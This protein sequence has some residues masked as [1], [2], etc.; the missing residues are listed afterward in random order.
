MNRLRWHQNFIF[1]ARDHHVTAS[2]MSAVSGLSKCVQAPELKNSLR[3]CDFSSSVCS[4]CPIDSLNTL[5][6]VRRL[7]PSCGRGHAILSLHLLS[8]TKMGDGGDSSGRINSK[9]SDPYLSFTQAVTSWPKKK[10]LQNL[11]ELKY[12]PLYALSHGMFSIRKC[13]A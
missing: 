9:D 1:T 7:A 2:F 10:N 8:G 13:S 12:T 3:S 5:S 11:W 6:F 4:R